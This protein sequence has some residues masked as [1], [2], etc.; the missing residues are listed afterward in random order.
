MAYY[1]DPYGNQYGGQHGGQYGGQY[2]GEQY[3]DTPMM[4]TP[5]PMMQAPKTAPVSYVSPQMMP[6]PVSYILPPPAARPAQVN[7]CRSICLISS[8]MIMLVC[9]ILMLA[10]P[11]YAAELPEKAVAKACVETRTGC[12]SGLDST[13]IEA[14][15]TYTKEQCKVD[16]KIFWGCQCTTGQTC[17]LASHFDCSNAAGTTY[18]LAMLYEWWADGMWT[19]GALGCGIAL[20]FITIPAFMAG[21]QTYSSSSV[22]AFS[23]CSGLWCGPY[24][25]IGACFSTVAAAWRVKDLAVYD[26]VRNLCANVP[27]NAQC[28]QMLWCST[29]AELK[30]GEEYQIATTVATA[31]TAYFIAGF[32]ML[33]GMFVCCC[34]KA[35]P[36]PAKAPMPVNTQMP[37]Q[38]VYASPPPQP[39]Y[40]SPQPQPAMMMYPEPM[41]DQPMYEQPMYEY[42]QP[43]YTQEPQLTGYGQGV[44][45][46]D[47]TYPG[48]P[49]A[50]Q[51]MYR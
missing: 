40:A 12:R 38:P 32:V 36:P 19:L 20:F 35:P 24:I 13:L 7:R 23:V 1:P 30:S 9:S 41:Y 3:Y 2:G 5:V 6:M 39:V 22:V 34:C 28:G 45:V 11:Y 43:M 48:A 18:Y 10:L 47:Y 44:P 49:G 17:T 51:R 46:I 42:E 21:M 8:G 15:N 25:F 4:M 26:T 14:R 37:P 33:F 29:L 50:E 27:A 31:G 16:L